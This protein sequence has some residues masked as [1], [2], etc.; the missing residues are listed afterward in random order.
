MLLKQQRDIYLVIPKNIV[1]N[2]IFDFEIENSLP[3]IKVS[4][5]KKIW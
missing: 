1:Y 5:N 4:F 2:S 3:D